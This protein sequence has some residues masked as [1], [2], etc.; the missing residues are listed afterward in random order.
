MSFTILITFS[1]ILFLI[2][3]AINRQG[4]VTIAFTKGWLFGFAYDVDIDEGIKYHTFQAA[5][6][7]IILN[8]EYD[9][10]HG[11]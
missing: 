1:L 2:V 5:V 3:A 11:E 10:G 4:H 8:I 6:G 9:T 7:F